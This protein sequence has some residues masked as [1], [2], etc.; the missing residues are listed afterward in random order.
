MQ[1]YAILHITGL[2]DILTKL[3]LFSLIVAALGVE[4]VLLSM[5]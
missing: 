4:N 2:K 5:I 1:M 3:E